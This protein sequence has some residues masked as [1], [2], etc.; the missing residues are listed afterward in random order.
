MNGVATAPPCERCGAEATRTVAGRLL[1]D[2]PT[3]HQGPGDQETRHQDQGSTEGSKGLYVVPG[4]PGGKQRREPELYGLLRDH[5][6]GQLQPLPVELG[7]LPAV[8][9]RVTD[10]KGRDV[11]VTA[12]MHTVADD[13]GLLLGLRLAANEERPVP[14]STRFCAERCGFNDHRQAS[15]VLRAL[16]RVGVVVCVGSLDARGKPDGTKLYAPPR[17][18]AS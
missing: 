4:S 3:C 2:R 10:F 6:R 5:T 12:A 7:P 17:G 13:I 9:E 14:Y 18:D 11:V 8:G 1:C 15:R 16:E